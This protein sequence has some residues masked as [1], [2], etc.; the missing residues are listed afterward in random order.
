MPFESGIT[1]IA[2]IFWFDE[3]KKA[4][5][6]PWYWINQVIKEANIKFDIFGID[7]DG[8]ETTSLSQIK[9]TLHRIFIFEL[10]LE[11]SNKKTIKSCINQEIQEN[12]SYF[13]TGSWGGIFNRIMNPKQKSLL[14]KIA[15]KSL[16]YGTRARHWNSENT[17]C[18]NCE[19]VD[20]VPHRYF[21]CTEERIMWDY[22]SILLGGACSGNDFPK[23]ILS[24]ETENKNW[25]DLVV[26]TT[27]WVI[28][29]NF[30]KAFFDNKIMNSEA[31][32]ISLGNKLNNECA[33][34][35]RNYK[36]IYEKDIRKNH[37]VLM[38]KLSL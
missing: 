36:Y 31:K 25:R 28:H 18:I 4:I 9:K 38:S 26:H 14:W 37:T 27:I 32:I 5:R 24:Q 29:C 1:E 19:C 11:E 23:N 16:I 21:L 12:S 34:I 35:Q 30:Y 20:T 7:S 17:L 2:K 6:S 22:A 13:N 33:R 10:P 8:R 3:V 15:T